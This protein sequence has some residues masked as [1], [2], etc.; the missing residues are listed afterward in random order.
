MLQILKVGFVSI[1]L[2]KGI[3]KG[4]GEPLLGSKLK[5]WVM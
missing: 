3:E 2:F 1:R 5:N 4:G